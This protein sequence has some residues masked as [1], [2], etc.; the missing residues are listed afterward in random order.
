MQPRL[1]CPACESHEYTD[2]YHM[3]GV[4]VHVGFLWPSRE[5]AR[6]APT[7]D[8]VLSFCTTCNY[9]WNRALDPGKMSY[10]PEYEVSLHHSP[11]YQAFL[12]QQVARL[13]RQY[14][15]QNKTVLEIGC[16][17]GHF[18]EMMCRAGNNIGIGIDPCAPATHNGNERIRFLQEA[19]TERHKGINADF[20]GLRQI[21]HV[22]ERPQAM[23][24]ALRQ[25]ITPELGP[26][27]YVEVPNGHYIIEHVMQWMVF[28]E[29]V[30]YYTPASL[31]TLFKRCGF[32]VLDLSPCY[33]DG[34]YLGLEAILVGKSTDVQDTSMRLHSDQLT[35]F[36]LRASQCVA[37][38]KRKL[39]IYA[40]QG[41]TIV[42]W[43]SAGRGI[44]FLNALRP[45]IDYVVDV[46]PDRQG[47][48]IPVTGQQVI[49]PSDLPQMDP[50]VI[51]LTNSTYA[52]EIKQHVQRLGLAPDYIS[53]DNGSTTVGADFVE[54]A[55]DFEMVTV[56][57]R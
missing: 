56:R 42:S 24:R 36:T 19:Y 48:Y 25:N 11:T 35:A 45:Q 26:V 52:S 14:M 39:T 17:T 43:G 30:A 38:L 41:K 8:I 2:F 4:P 12:E 3:E 13:T 9:I 40:E 49:S 37:D 15:L 44:T 18:L 47:Y 16:G 50:D 51:V 20:I 5:S 10:G 23:L 6:R 31:T 55:T 34:Q 46:N 32:K 21:F 57:R 53:I 28:Y 29:Q 22:I 27:I 1:A 54:R 33:V 7:G